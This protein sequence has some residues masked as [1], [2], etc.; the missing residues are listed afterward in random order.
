MADAAVGADGSAA[1]TLHSTTAQVDRPAGGAAGM[2]IAILRASGLSV[3]FRNPS[4][5]FP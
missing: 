5:N 1:V 4:G 3:R 2:R